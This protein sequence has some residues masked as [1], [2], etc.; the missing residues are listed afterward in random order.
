MAR[1]I[2][3]EA[4]ASYPHA[5]KAIP[6]YDEPNGKKKHSLAL[7]FTEAAWNTPEMVTLRGAVL[8]CAKQRFGDK[9]EA[10]IAEGSLKLPFRRDVAAK[11]YPDTVFRFMNC[12]SSEDHPPEVV[13][14]YAGP[15]GK[16]EKI[17]DS[18]ALY[19]GCI[20]RASVTV[21]AYDN[22]SKGVALGLGNIQIVGDGP[23]LDETKSASDDFGTPAPRP[24]ASAAS[25]IDALM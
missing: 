18:K 16:P 4:T 7:L 8:D 25:S 10:M 15:D 11:N 1:Y 3:A 22:K 19:P 20:V 13:G 23:R 14:I 17:T 2:T 24:T 5:F 9:A 21:F 12:T 6:P